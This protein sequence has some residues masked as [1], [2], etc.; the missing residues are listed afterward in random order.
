MEEIINQI[1]LLED[2]LQQISAEIT[3]LL[4]EREEKR[5]LLQKLRQRGKEEK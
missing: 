4:A 2:D 5:Q 3:A 1:K